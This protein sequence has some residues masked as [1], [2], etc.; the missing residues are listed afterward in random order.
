LA[1]GGGGDACDDGLDERVRRQLASVDA[2]IDALLAE[3]AQAERD[4]VEVPLPATL[5]ATAALRLRTDPDGLAAELAR[6]MPRAPSTAARLGTRFHAWVESYVGQ[7]VLLEPHDLPGAADA[8][9]SDDA[10]LVALTAAFRDGPFGE[11]EPLSVEAPFSLTL[12]GHVVVGRIDAVYEDDD[13]YLVVDWKTGRD[14]TADPTQLAIYRLAW[15]EMRS[16]PLDRVR[17]A[18]YY[19]RT[20]EVVPY[21]D[22]P[23]RAALEASLLANP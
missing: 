20:G 13:G 4:T 2:E 21:H 17:A 19:V 12:R 6:P 1:N 5:S 23:D 8:E 15:A 16:V 10:D 18:F 14:P 11:R 22:L 9:I 3:S 7:Q